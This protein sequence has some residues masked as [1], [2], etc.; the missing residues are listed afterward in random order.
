MAKRKAV[1]KPEESTQKQMFDAM[2]EIEKD[3]GV[4]FDVI[5]E[6]IKHSIEKASKSGDVVFNIDPE[7]GVFEAFERKTVVEEVTDS[8]KEI[9]LISARE[10]DV[11]A[12]IGEKVK[13]PINTRKL[14]RN[15]VA[16]A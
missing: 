16:N 10:Y 12:G 4:P 5:L 8:K 15:S 11:N 3:K 2:R 9:D 7:N 14:G 1:E 13:V 6:N